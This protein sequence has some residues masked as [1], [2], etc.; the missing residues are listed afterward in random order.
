MPVLLMVPLRF[1]LARI[2]VDPLEPV[3][4]IVPSFLTLSLLLI[5]TAAPLVGLTEP[6][7][8]MRMSS[9]AV[10]VATGVVIAVLITVSA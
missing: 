1:V 4:W 10:P 9:L 3:I 8:L 7:E 2:P 6:V 5:V